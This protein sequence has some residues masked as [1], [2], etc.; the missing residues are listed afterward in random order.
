MY[1]D[2]RKKLNISLSFEESIFL[3]W[4]NFL[5]DKEQFWTGKMAQE[6]RCLPPTWQPKYDPRTHM[7]ERTSFH[8]L[9]SDLYM[10]PTVY[11]LIHMCKHTH[12]HDSNK[13]F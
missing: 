5:Y 4:T 3:F 7:A 11:M 8:K 12:I 9:T 6:I 10:G 1:M 2:L 13:C